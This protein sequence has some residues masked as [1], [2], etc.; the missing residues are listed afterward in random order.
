MYAR[1][2]ARRPRGTVARGLQGG[3]TARGAYGGATAR[4]GGQCR[5]S[6]EDIANLLAMH[7]PTLS[8]R[9]KGGGIG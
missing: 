1:A 6:A 8:R 4:P 2:A 5:G 9:L 3:V 7:R